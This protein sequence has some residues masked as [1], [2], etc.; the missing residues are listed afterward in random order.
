MSHRYGERLLPHSQGH[1]NPSLPSASCILSCDPAKDAPTGQTDSVSVTKIGIDS[2]KDYERGYTEAWKGALQPPTPQEM[3]SWTL[4]QFRAHLEDLV[5]QK[6]QVSGQAR[7]DLESRRLSMIDRITR[8]ERAEMKKRDTA[9]KGAATHSRQVNVDITARDA[10][11]ILLLS[12]HRPRCRA[13][14]ARPGGKALA[15]EAVWTK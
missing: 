13:S 8:I 6:R 9:R 10:N 12:C 14:A 3:S 1:P 15:E 2:I 4:I 5:M 11:L 7:A